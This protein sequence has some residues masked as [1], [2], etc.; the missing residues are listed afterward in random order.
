V[1]EV[2]VSESPADDIAKP[3]AW[4]FRFLREPAVVAL[5][6]VSL[7]AVG[8]VIWSQVSA[9]RNFREAQ[10]SLMR[11]VATGVAGEVSLYIGEKTRRVRLFAEENRELLSDFVT[12][13]EDTVQHA[14]VQQKIKRYFPDHFAFT[15]RMAD[16]SLIPDH[17]GVFVGQHCRADIEAHW[18]TLDSE[19]IDPPGPVIHPQAGNY[20]YDTMTRW[21]TRDGEAAV[22]FVSFYPDRLADIISDFQLPGHEIYLVRGDIENL[23]EIAAGGVRDRL[24]RDIRLA[25]DE[26]ARIAASV[27]VEQTRWLAVTLPAPGFFEAAQRHGMVQSVLL[28]VAIV[29]FW[30]LACVVIVRAM[31][32]R[33]RADAMVRLLNDRLSD[34][35]RIARLG[36][37]NL[38]LGS[39]ELHWSDEIFEI[40]GIDRQRFGA[41]FEAFVDTIHPDDRD[42]VLAHYQDSVDTGVPY[43]IENRIV[44]NDD[45]A[46]RWVRERCAHRR[47]RSGAVTES[48]GTVHDI[49]E[50]K[51]AELRLA[52]VNQKL[53]GHVAELQFSR[54]HLERQSEDL[55]ALAEELDAEKKRAEKLSVTD[56]LT[57]L[58]N[59]L[60]LDQAFVEELERSRRY[61]HPL[62]IVL[63]DVDHFKSVNDT[64]GHQVGDEVL[65]A[66]AHILQESV[67]GTD[68][69][70]RWG[71]EEFLVICPETPAEGAA[72][73]AEKIRA[74]IEAHAFPQVGT[75][76]ASFGV[77]TL[78][79]DED[80]DGITK[81]ADDALYRAKESGR[82]RVVAD[83]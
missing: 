9:D 12:A 29:L 45:G 60:K 65:V 10:T 27:P 72:L 78:A 81:R 17:L 55:V 7:F 61:G 8:F 11:N 43:D 16:G 1:T 41:S 18:L 36:S 66:V 83:D 30:L 4:D 68:I 14:L 67:R 20:H 3:T 75:K 38:N 21:M 76:T 49:T 69:T 53:E 71:G 64:F 57:G 34:A 80:I 31:T 37:W 47:D 54:D 28:A 15:L 33:R 46:V 77:A 22:L 48:L 42:M 44:R 73:L 6:L 56:R 79:E 82:N 63:F 70:G 24:Q 26:L 74:A 2:R 50:L 40:F 62:S 39:N 25:P 59:R 23:I 5:T 32:Q 58:N 35:Q 51:D 52:E 13:G 19:G